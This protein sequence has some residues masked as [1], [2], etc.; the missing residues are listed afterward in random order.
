MKTETRRI[1]FTTTLP[2]LAML[3]AHPLA[4]SQD[5]PPN[6]PQIEIDVEKGINA[7]RKS[8]GLPILQSDAEVTKIA[9]VHSDNMAS[10]KVEFGHGGFDDRFAQIKGHLQ[11]A[12][13]AEN[14][15]RHKRI[16]DHA[17]TAISNWLASPGHLENING[18]FDLTGVAAATSKDGTVY[19]TQLFVKLRVTKENAPHQ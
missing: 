4:A 14:I 16:T 13:A 2:L 17:K 7:H 5:Q 3:W 6:L 12:S 9:R 8:S 18:D 10:G 15:S 11:I 1:L 19:I